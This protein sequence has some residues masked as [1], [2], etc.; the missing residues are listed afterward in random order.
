LTRSRPGKGT[1]NVGASHVVP[2][3]TLTA[4]MSRRFTSEALCP[5][6]DALSAAGEED[7][8]P[9]NASG[10]SAAGCRRARHWSSHTRAA[11]K[12]LGEGCVLEILRPKIAQRA[13]LRW[14]HR[15]RWRPP[16]VSGVAA[17]CHELCQVLLPGQARPPLKVPPSKRLPATLR[18]SA[19]SNWQ[20]AT[21]CMAPTATPG[22]GETEKHSRREGH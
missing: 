13:H 12:R 22:P 7:P 2:K 10:A 14:S 1:A 15:L 19:C 11:G 17:P 21:A 5:A 3:R 8:H 16:S 6:A 20:H 18:S 4:S 9:M